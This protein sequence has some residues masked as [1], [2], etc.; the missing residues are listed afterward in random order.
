MSCARRAIRWCTSTRYGRSS[1]KPDARVPV[2]AVKNSVGGDRPDHQSRRSCLPELCTVSRC[3][4][5]RSPASDCTGR[6]R[7]TWRGARA[8]SE[9]A[10]RWGRRR[11]AVVWAVL[12][13]VLA[14]GGGGDRDRRAGGTGGLEAGGVVLVWD[15]R[16]RSAGADG[17][18]GDVAGGGA[19]GRV[20]FR[21]GRRRESI[22][23][24]RYG[25]SEE[26]S[27]GR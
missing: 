25:M 7:I 12:R 15:E 23:W 13:E 9:S 21:R 27:D 5:W 22:R 18:R 2:A 3:W 10:W 17:G 11:A 8:R 24:S 16:E 19:V 20:L 1:V 26:L 4:R 6:C 14:A